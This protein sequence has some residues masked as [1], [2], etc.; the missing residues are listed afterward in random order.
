MRYLCATITYLLFSGSLIA[1]DKARICNG[2]LDI[3][4]LSFGETDFLREHMIHIFDSAQ[5]HHKQGSLQQVKSR[6]EINKLLGDIRQGIHLE[7][8]LE[9]PARIVVEQEVIKPIKLWASVRGSDG[10]VADWVL[11][12]S[13]G[14]LVS[15]NKVRGELVV[16]LAPYILNILNTNED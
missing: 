16:Q 4:V 1:N 12:D 7:L 13:K 2:Q 3:A 5:F 10:F 15:L 6:Q 11:E 9:E 8:I 14:G